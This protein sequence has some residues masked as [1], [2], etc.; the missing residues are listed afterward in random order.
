MFFYI[1]KCVHV[2]VHKLRLYAE[3]R[4][5]LWQL[6]LS[7]HAVVSEEDLRWSRLKASSLAK[8]SHQSPKVQLLLLKQIE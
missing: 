5:Q 6:L 8:P 1:T 7:Y 2:Y 3:I 4:G